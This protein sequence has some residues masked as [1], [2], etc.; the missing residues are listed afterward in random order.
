[1]QEKELFG[2][3][4]GLSEPWYVAGVEFDAEERK[5]D[6]TIDFRRGGV[7][8][9]G[10]CGAGGCKA[11]DTEQR[12]WRHLNF[13]Q[14]ETHLHARLPRV[15]CGRCGIKPVEVQWARPGSGFTLFFEALVL[16]L[17][18]QM[19]VK[20]VARLLGVHD[21]RLWRML[22][23][24]VEQARE[25]RDDSGVERVGVDET[26]AKRGHDY[27][28]LFADLDGPRVL[29]V[30]KGRGA[31]T[32]EEFRSD[33]EAHGGQAEQITEVCCDM[34]PA[35]I[36]GIEQALPEAAI[37]FDKFHVL[38]LISD[39]VDKTR[40]SER[41]DYPELKGWRYALLRNPE[42]MSDG[43]LDFAAELL[44]QTHMKTARAFHLRLAFIDLY[45]QPRR[46]AEAYLKRWYSWAI[47]SRVPAM[48][49]A[50][51]TIKRHW[52]GVLRWFVSRISNGLLE[53]LNS[54]VQA[55]KAK[56]RGYRSTAY[57][58][59]IIYL[60]AGKLDLQATHL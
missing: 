28:S 32:V 23:H 16:T 43:Q 33:L 58:Q 10:E 59:T 48:V 51:R 26:A 9:C 11:Y 40:R 38:R 49:D 36:R 19:P 45:A 50:A 1:M 24:Y 6:L 55:A 30:A 17:S 25:R 35:F 44:R 52:N 18:A 5:L 39:A 20:A 46:G 7:F 42:T 60:I 47:R 3:A 34:S 41:P 37:T 14:F 22:K 13:F 57:L 54:L 27:V 8:A 2:Q 15:Q 4:L 12:S 53:G 31:E 21:T 56:A 29:Y